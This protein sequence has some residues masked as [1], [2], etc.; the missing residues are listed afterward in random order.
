M[1]DPGGLSALNGRDAPP[2]FTKETFTK[3]TFIRETIHP[4]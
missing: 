3:E 2:V 1:I 4:P